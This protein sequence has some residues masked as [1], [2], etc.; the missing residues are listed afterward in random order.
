MA[1]NKVQLFIDMEDT[2]ASLERAGTN[3]KKET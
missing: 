3:A 1:K 2:Y